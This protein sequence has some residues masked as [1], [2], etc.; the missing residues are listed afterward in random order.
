MVLS[1]YQNTEQIN[2]HTT[3]NDNE[4]KADSWKPVIINEHK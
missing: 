2:T 1:S 4:R 3:T